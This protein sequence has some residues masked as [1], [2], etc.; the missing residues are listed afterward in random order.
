MMRKKIPQDQDEEKN[1]RRRKWIAR[2]NFMREKKRTNDGHLRFNSDQK[3][4]EKTKEDLSTF[5][6]AQL[7][8]SDGQ[9][10]ITQKK[11]RN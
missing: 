1:A 5:V 2:G 11:K 10:R 4:T 8:L 9:T 6:F 7:V 3:K